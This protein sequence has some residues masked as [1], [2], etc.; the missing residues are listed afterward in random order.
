MDRIAAACDYLYELRKTRSPVPALPAGIVPRS[1]AEGYEVQERLVRKLMDHHGSRPIGYKI[2]CTSELAQKA[3]AVDGPFFG[4][5]LTHSS[6]SEP[7]QAERLGL[8]GPLYGGRVR[9]RDG[10]GCAGRSDV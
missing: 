1:L 4:V 5:L 9:I 7:G 3:L 6:Q 2:A 8:H 10:R